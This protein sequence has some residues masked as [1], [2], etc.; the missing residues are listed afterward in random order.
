MEEIN[1]INEKITRGS[2]VH[3]KEIIKRELQRLSWTS[4]SFNNKTHNLVRRR[5]KGSKSLRRTKREDRKKIKK[6]KDKEMPNVKNRKF[7]NS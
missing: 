7:M 3:N 4:L 5:M 6:K 1:G 2:E